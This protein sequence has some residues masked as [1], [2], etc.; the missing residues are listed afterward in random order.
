MSALMVAILL[1]AFWSREPLYLAESFLQVHDQ[2]QHYA[3]SY[4]G[5]YIVEM[6]NKSL[7]Q[8]RQIN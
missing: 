4:K 1:L 2:G 8:F 6:V 3:Y 7:V 5:K